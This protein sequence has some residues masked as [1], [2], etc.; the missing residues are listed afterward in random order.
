MLTRTFFKMRNN[1]FKPEQVFEEPKQNWKQKLF[2]N[3]EQSFENNN[4]L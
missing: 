2:Q 1:F 4:I 3:Y